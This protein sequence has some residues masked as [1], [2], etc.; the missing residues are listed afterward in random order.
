MTCVLSGAFSHEGGHFGP[1]DFD[2]GD[3]TVDHQP[4][5]DTADECICLIAMHGQ[6]RLNGLVGRLMQPFVRL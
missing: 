4:V 5:V 2:L 3:E 6:L 1:G